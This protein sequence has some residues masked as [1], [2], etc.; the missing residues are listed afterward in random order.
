MSSNTPDILNKILARKAEE[1][2]ERVSR[3]SLAEVKDQAEQSG[4]V[5]GFEDAIRS[6]LASGK[7]AIIAEIKKA[8]PSKGVL[9]AD[10][11]PDQ[12]AKS[13]ADHGATC[14]SVLTDIDFF[15]GSDTYLE[16]ARAAC[17]I[18]VLRKDF[19]IDPYQLYEARVLG[20]DC[21]LL[22]VS[23]LNDDQLGELAAV[24]RQL[25]LDVLIEVHDG[26]ELNRA[27]ATDL[28]LIGI[29]NRNLHTFDTSL[30]TTISLL[31][32]IPQDRI[33]VTESGI[34]TPGD[35]RL[36]QDSGVHTFLVGEAFMRAD[37]PG[38]KLAALFRR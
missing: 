20:A 19:I 14:L 13:Y 34:H 15:Q 2:A 31:G 30:D 3:I 23:A 29:N 37:D 28:A 1:V 18:P 32:D 5:R 17:K 4:P 6:R 8:S 27:L 16:S 35:V 9:R 38:E 25:E 33:V 7:S 21:V 12:I 36:M 22:I 26:Q 10:F 24:A 11:Q